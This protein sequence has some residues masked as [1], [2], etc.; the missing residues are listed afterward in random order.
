MN[1]AVADPENRHR[2][3]EERIFSLE[4][5]MGPV[6]RRVRWLVFDDPFRQRERVRDRNPAIWA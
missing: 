5:A 3:A 4:A 2:R 1:G 6:I